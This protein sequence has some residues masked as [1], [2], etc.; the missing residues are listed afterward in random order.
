MPFSNAPGIAL[1]I[2]EWRFNGRLEAA[3]AP[4]SVAWLSAQLP[5]KGLAL[6][7]RWSGEA[8]WLPLEHNVAL[9]E[10]NA[11]THPR[12]GQILLYAGPKSVP[13][14]LI[15]YG[16]CVFACRAGSLAGNHVITLDIDSSRLSSLGHA[17]LYQGAQPLHLRLAHGGG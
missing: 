17:L 6:H 12:P 4:K 10:E 2:G 3:A 15:P 5:L 11:V 8:A 13:E 1:E 14:L 9:D 7:A 16:F